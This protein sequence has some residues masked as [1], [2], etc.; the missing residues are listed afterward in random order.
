MA[1]NLFGRYVWLL[2]TLRKYK[3]LTYEEINDLWQQ[4]G[5]NYG[6]ELPLRTFHNHRK[7]IEEIF[8]ICI[9]C[10]TKN[11]YRYYIETPEQLDNDGLKCWLIDSYAILNQMQADKKLK[12]RIIF[13][14]IPSGHTWLSTITDAMRKNKIL[15]ITHQGFGKPEASRFEIEPYCLKVVKRRW[16]V[17]A[18]SPYYSERNKAKG[19]EPE[20]VFLTY[21]LDRILNIEETNETFILKKEFDVNEFFKGCCGVITSNEKIER[22]VLKAYGD[23]PDYLRTLPLHC[24][25]VELSSDDES[26]LFEYHVKPT[27]DFYQLLLEQGDQLEVLEPESIRNEMRN[28]AMNMMAYYKKKKETCKK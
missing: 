7:A 22:V 24:S 6:D 17:I 27:F 12:G 5:I 2:D 1:S 9:A 23:F 14:N 8:D 16:Y 25:Q 26:T 4:C 21:A 13:E 28:F 15:R 11:G 3:C 20:D 19:Y 10:D 18:R